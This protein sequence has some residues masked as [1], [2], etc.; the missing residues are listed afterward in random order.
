M[1]NPVLLSVLFESDFREETNHLVGQELF[2]RVCDYVDVVGG[3]RQLI[4][5]T[6]SKYVRSVPNPDTDPHVFRPP[7]SGFFY[8]PSVIKQKL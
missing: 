4:L 8:H 2:G 6:N 7:G 3:R 1:F 5:A